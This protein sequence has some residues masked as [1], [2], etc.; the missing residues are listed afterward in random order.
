MRSLNL[1]FELDL[2]FSFFCRQLLWI[3]IQAISCGCFVTSLESL[4]VFFSGY[5]PLVSSSTA[6]IFFL[7]SSCGFSFLHTPAPLI[8][9]ALPALTQ[10]KASSY[11]GCLISATASQNCRQP[12]S[13]NPPGSKKTPGAKFCNHSSHK[14]LMIDLRC[15][16]IFRAKNRSFAC[17]VHRLGTLIHDGLW[18]CSL[19][20]TVSFP[21]HPWACTSCYL[22][23]QFDC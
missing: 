16:F 5:I 3:S 22:G 12:D 1:Q 10:D 8:R 11:L 6:C 13:K 20:K 17:P 19:R 23:L 9:R 21:C 7:A 18:N 4:A 15:V 14:I 2:L